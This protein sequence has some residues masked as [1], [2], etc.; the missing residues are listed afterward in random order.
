MALLADT[1]VVFVKNISTF[2]MNITNVFAGTLVRNHTTV[3][4]RIV[5]NLLV[6]PQI[7]VY[8][9]RLILLKRM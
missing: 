4:F 8:M 5:I 6:K 9:N 7:G 3:G 2:W 1:D